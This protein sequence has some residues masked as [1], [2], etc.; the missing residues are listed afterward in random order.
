MFSQDRR[1]ARSVSD[2][3]DSLIARRRLP[4]NVRERSATSNQDDFAELLDLVRALDDLNLIAPDPPGTFPWRDDQVAIAPAPCRSAGTRPPAWRAWLISVGWHHAVT[5]SAVLVGV[6]VTLSTRG[7][8]P[9]LSADDLLKQSE[10]ALEELF[11][12]GQGLYRVWDASHRV[13]EPDGRVTNWEGTIHEWIEGLQPPRLARRAIDSRGRLLWV[14]VADRDSHG[15]VRSR[16]Y[17]TSR[18]SLRTAGFGNCGRNSKRA[19]T[20]V[21]CLR[22]RGPNRARTVLLA[23]VRSGRCWRACL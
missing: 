19:S 11:G 23:E 13:E 20:G 14:L 9:A 3:A 15:Q 7:T 10:A 2:Y 8:A 17:Y 4:S 12:S 18:Q 16:N 22:L 5:V 21:D 6:F 1:R